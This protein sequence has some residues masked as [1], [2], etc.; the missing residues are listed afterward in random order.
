MACPSEQAVKGRLL[1]CHL[2]RRKVGSETGIPSHALVDHPT[3]PPLNL[4]HKAFTL[5]RA[6][7]F[8]S[9]NRVQLALPRGNAADPLLSGK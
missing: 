1:A 9:K 8:L 2:S 3:N 7:S 4:R 5:A 6:Y